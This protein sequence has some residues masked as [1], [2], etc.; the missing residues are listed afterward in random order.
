MTI[1]LVVDVLWA[2]I[3]RQVLRTFQIYIEFKLI[4]FNLFPENHWVINVSMTLI[5]SQHGPD[6]PRKMVA[7]KIP[8]CLKL[9]PDSWCLDCIIH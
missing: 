5:N 7:V 4:Y 1:E 8:N 9:E 6:G 2:M 3:E